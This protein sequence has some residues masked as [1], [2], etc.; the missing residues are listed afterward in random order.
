[1]VTLLLHHRR[2]LLSW[3]TTM[4][5][6]QADD[7]V[8]LGKEKSYLLVFPD[9]NINKV[10]IQ[11]SSSSRQDR[12]QSHLV[13][14]AN[15]SPSLHV[16]AMK[17]KAPISSKNLLELENASFDQSSGRLLAHMGSIHENFVSL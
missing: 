11:N 15:V 7:V 9:A 1:M 14:S 6:N 13:A 3:V 16:L 8:Y 5:G 2:L 17:L 4:T 12:Q 10:V